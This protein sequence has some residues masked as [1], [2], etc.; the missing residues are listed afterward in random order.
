MKIDPIQNQAGLVRFGNNKVSLSQ[1]GIDP[2]DVLISNQ[3]KYLNDFDLHEA[4]HKKEEFLTKLIQAHEHALKCRKLKGSEFSNRQYATHMELELNVGSTKKSFWVLAGNFEMNISELICGERG[5][6]TIGINKAIKMLP[7]NW[8]D[9]LPDNVN[10]ENM[11]K[12]KRLLMTSS[13]P[14]GDDKSAWQPCSDCYAWMGTNRF[15][16]P[17]TQ[18]W[19][20]FKNQDSK[21]VLEGRTLRDLLPRQD[22][23]TVSMSDKPIE[24]LNIEYS[25]TANV[26]RSKKRIS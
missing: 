24:T 19:S 23:Q 12:V 5:G 20:L 16:K 2:K 7:K 15:F 4:S 3:S 11:L 21:L 25:D 8:V 22:V 14:L 9:S 17:E 18:I 10:I 6:M 13:K 1:Y 26:T